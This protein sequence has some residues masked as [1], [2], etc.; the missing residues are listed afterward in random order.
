MN[1]Y[2]ITIVKKQPAT[3]NA[4]PDEYQAQTISCAA[5]HPWDAAHKCVSQLQ[6]QASILYAEPEIDMKLYQ[7]EPHQLPITRKGSKGYLKSWPSP[8]QDTNAFV[9]HLGDEYSQL[10]K[11]AREVWDGTGLSPEIKIAHIDTGYEVG[12]PALPE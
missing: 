1:T 6:D 9:W 10:A 11:A 4:G 3:K 12:H 8:P 5:S 7:E 2:N